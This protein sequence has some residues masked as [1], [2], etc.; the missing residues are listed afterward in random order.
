MRE[1]LLHSMRTFSRRVIA[2][3]LAAKAL[4]TQGRTRHGL[5]GQTIWLIGIN[6]DKGSRL[7]E[8]VHLLVFG[9]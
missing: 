2:H 8:F 1:Y 6:R 7:G 9:E 5:D 4:R 3:W